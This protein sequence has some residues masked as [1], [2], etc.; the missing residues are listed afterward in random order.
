MARHYLSSSSEEQQV[1]MT[2]LY[3]EIYHTYL[4]CK[5]SNRLI[6]GTDFFKWA[7]NASQENIIEQLHNVF[8]TSGLYNQ[9]FQ[10]YDAEIW[11]NVLQQKPNMDKLK[12]FL[13]I[14]VVVDT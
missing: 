10:V 12:A 13:D 3:W 2:P 1:N 8:H 4:L 11:C 5:Y 7:T 14:D 9:N 6:Y